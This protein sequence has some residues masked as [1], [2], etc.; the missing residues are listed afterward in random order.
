MK[1]NIIVLIILVIS[2]CSSIP[3]IEKT[4]SLDTLIQKPQFNYKIRSLPQTI[5]VYFNGQD[6]EFNLP[7]EAQ[8]FIANSYFYNSKIS[9][10][11]KIS[12]SNLGALDC[13]N[14][15]IQEDLIVIF[16]LRDKSQ[17]LEKQNCFKVMPKS[18]TFYVSNQEDNYGFSNTFFISR[19]DEK[20]QLINELDK[21]SERIIL[22]DS[23]KTLDKESIKG[24]LQELNKEVVELE[25]YGNN[26][27]S[28]DMFAKLL[29]VDRS[30]ERKRKLSRRISESISG[31]SRAREDIDTFFLS[32]DL[33]EARNL[34]PALDYISEKDY[35]VYILNSWSTKST[36]DKDDKDLSGSIHADFPIMMPIEVPEFIKDENRSREFALGYD[37]FE[38]ILMKYGDVN[39]RN[40]IY[41]GL[42]GKIILEDKKVKRIPYLFKI[43]DTGLE[44]L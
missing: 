29:M 2:A 15:L 33:K 12:F 25:T 1:N 27:S 42:S 31:D 8:G 41:K 4:E 9:Y 17:N 18:K 10:K 3:K 7:L 43:T 28:Q 44:I 39:Y 5:R 14:P 24:S 6:S 34:K 36:Y 23:N 30:Q 13:S 40:Y 19:D 16:N 32:V 38:I 35:E 11:P 21:Y 22:I 26:L 20:K 37:L